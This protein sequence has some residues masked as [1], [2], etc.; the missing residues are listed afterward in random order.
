MTT[1]Q[2]R[3]PRF[4]HSEF[5]THRVFSRNAMSSRAVPVKKMLEQVRNE[6]AMPNYWGKNQKGMSAAEE[7][8]P[9]EIVTAK[10]LW[11]NAANDAV[12][13]AEAMMELGMHK[14]DA[15]RILEPF[16]FITVIV[17]ATEYENF[18]RLRNHADAH[19]MIQELAVV[20]LA[21]Y[22]ESKP[23]P[24]GLKT[25]HLPYITDLEWTAL[26]MKQVTV[27]DLTK[28]SAARCARVSYLTHEGKNPTREEDLQLF[29][30]LSKAQ[31]PHLSPLEHQ[32]MPYEDEMTMYFGASSHHGNLGWRWV[33]FRKCLELGKPEIF[34]DI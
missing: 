17:T 28:F 14:Q 12:I 8:S 19:P 30:R 33:Q 10:K 26:A 6:P 31:P 13:W 4:I 24:V 5:M 18:F 15:N 32:A 21:E 7:L 2:L 20:M 22:I 11:L 29:D 34:W 9:E 27:E 1:F 25:Y 16:Q 23:D 3:Y